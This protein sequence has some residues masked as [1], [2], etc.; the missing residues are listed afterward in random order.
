MGE[1]N[2]SSYKESISC[3]PKKFTNIIGNCYLEFCFCK[4]FS[5][6]THTH[7]KQQKQKKY[8]NIVRIELIVVAVRMFFV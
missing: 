5:F 6:T 4:Y 3:L 1:T 2:E 8:E 7:A